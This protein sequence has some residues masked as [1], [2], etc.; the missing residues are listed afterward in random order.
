MD[1]FE[2]RIQ[3]NRQLFIALRRAV[4]ETEMPFLDFVFP[5]PDVLF[6]PQK[7]EDDAGLG[8]VIIN[9]GARRDDDVYIGAKP[10]RMLEKKH[11]RR[12]SLETKGHAGL[13]DRL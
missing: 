11:E 10:L 3:K 5:D 7:R 2:K 1:V 13:R 8:D 6:D 12:P 4:G 9:V